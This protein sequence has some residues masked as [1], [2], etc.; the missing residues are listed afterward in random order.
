MKKLS[1]SLIAIA[2]LAVGAS[3]AAFADAEGLLKTS[4]C[5]KCHAADK[6]KSG[7]SWKKVAEKYKGKADAEAKLF[8]HVTTGPKVKIDG[9]EETHAKIK[10]TDEAAIKEVIGFILKH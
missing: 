7:P 8:T 3:T 10:S 9:E 6:D 1:L 5:T 2:A 4:K